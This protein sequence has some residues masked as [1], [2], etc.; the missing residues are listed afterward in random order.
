M[1]K[2]P[3]GRPYQRCRVTDRYSPWWDWLGGGGDWLCPH[4]GPWR[5]SYL[6]RMFL[7]RPS[8]LRRSAT[9]CRSAEF[10]FSRK[11]ARMAIWFSFS[12]RASRER[13]AATLFFLRR[14]QYLSSWRKDGGG[15]TKFGGLIYPHVGEANILTDYL[16]LPRH[17]E[18]TGRLPV[19]P[20]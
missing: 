2:K 13:F 18:A 15:C 10:S 12:L 11:P 16:W 4:R 20:V 17:C 19:S 7:Q 14:A 3:R 9:S 8:S 1:G 5:A 6:E